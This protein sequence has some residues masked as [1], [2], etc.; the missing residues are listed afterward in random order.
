LLNVLIVPEF[1][2]PAPPAPPVWPEPPFPPLIVP[3]L[4]P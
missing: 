1:A 2:S 3:L 4:A